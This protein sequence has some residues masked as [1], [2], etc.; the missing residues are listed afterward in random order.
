M[1]FG[2]RGMF[3]SVPP[4]PMGFWEKVLAWVLGGMLLALFVGVV[5]W[6]VSK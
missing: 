4:D 5:F 3:K 1:C 6:V 2:G